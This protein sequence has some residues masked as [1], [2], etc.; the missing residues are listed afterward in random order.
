MGPHDPSLPDRPT[1]DRSF[2]KDLITM[3][4]PPQPARVLC[5]ARDPSTLATVVAPLVD[6]DTEVV[7][8]ELKG[9]AD[10]LDGLEKDSVGALILGDALRTFDEAELLSLV[11]GCH[12]VLRDGGRLLL[13]DQLM[14]YDRMAPLTGRTFLRW[15]GVR[16]TSD[17]LFGLLERSGFW[18]CLV[19][20]RSQF[21]ADVVVR[22]E[23]VVQHAHL[24]RS[25]TLSTNPS[26]RLIK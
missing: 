7:Q 1:A 18:D 5:I 23:K 9:A 17:E 4:L 25:P 3:A 14:P 2:V 24:D 11:Q 20:R 6:G 19:L 16:F 21:A 22:G 13:T 8:V 10:T 26:F 15:L 12:R